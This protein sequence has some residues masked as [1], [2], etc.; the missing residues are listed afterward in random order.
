[1]IDNMRWLMDR[2]DEHE[3]QVSEDTLDEGIIDRIRGWVQSLGEPAKRL[4]TRN[5][6]DFENRLR[7][8]YRSYVPAQARS[9]NKDWVWSKVTYA[10]L[11]RFVTGIL[12]TDARDLDT[13]L[14]NKPV[15]DVF[16]SIIST[17]PAGTGTPSIPPTSSNISNNTSV[18]SPTITDGLDS[19][20]SKI[21]SMAV[22]DGLAYLEQRRMDAKA[23]DPDPPLHRHGN[24]GST[25][26]NQA[27]TGSIEVDDIKS[28]IA[29]IKNGLAAMKRTAP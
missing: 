17:A 7:I 12:S 3:I 26:G 10:D 18:I 13:V 29:T 6:N 19:Y 9:S 16:R 24:D 15:A 1:M 5:F 22:L 23:L 27:D 4:G 8:K 20:P 21:A 28:A 25:V 11:H 14:K 2:V